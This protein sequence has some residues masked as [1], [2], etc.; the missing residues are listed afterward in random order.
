MIPE[1][2]FYHGAALSVLVSRREFT[3]LS[4]IVDLG[5][6]YAVNNTLGLYIKHATKSDSPWQFT[7]TP[8]NQQEIR[9]LFQRFDEKTFVALVCGQRGICLLTF[10]EYAATLPEDFNSQKVLIVRR[11][12]GGG[13][14]VS[15]SAGRR[16]R[17]VISLSRYPEGL[18]NHGR[19]R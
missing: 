10:G 7:F 17:G 3:G 4:R 15:G 6:A 5:S 14:R 2:Q 9:K 16:M 12:S 8:D 11:P 1:Y 19:P 18:F 13:F